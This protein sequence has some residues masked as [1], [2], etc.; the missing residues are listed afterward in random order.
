MGNTTSNIFSTA[1]EYIIANKIDPQIQHISVLYI[2]PVTYF[3]V[4]EN[5]A[6]KHGTNL[7]MLE[8]FI[9]EMC[10]KSTPISLFC[11]LPVYDRL[12][13]RTVEHFKNAPLTQWLATEK[14]SFGRYILSA[15]FA[16]AQC[17]NITVHP[18]DVRTRQYVHYNTLM[19]AW[20]KLT[21]KRSPKRTSKPPSKRKSKRSP[22][23]TSKTP[24][25]RKS[26]QINCK[27]KAR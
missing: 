8:R 7:G 16:N 3:I 26:K 21:P 24:S 27:P 11:K 1:K 9:T 13:G 15:L 20:S 22:N 18:T 12:D 6:K 4:G 17:K 19:S 23:R 14:S 25:K 10:N 2:E 5:V